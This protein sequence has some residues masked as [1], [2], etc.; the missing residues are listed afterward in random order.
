MQGRDIAR[1]CGIPEEY[2]LKI[3][4]QLARARVLRSE[5]GRAGGFL[6]RKTPSRTTLLE[7][8]EAIQG[9]VSGDLVSRK[10]IK[11]AEPAKDAVES[12]CGEIARYAKSLLRKTTICKLMKTG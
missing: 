7:I 9:P 3:L 10:E 1:A 8:V 4:Q 5:R 11:G 6:L 12:V 2:L